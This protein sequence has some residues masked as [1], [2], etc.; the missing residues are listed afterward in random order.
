MLRPLTLFS[1]ASMNTTEY[2]DEVD[3]LRDAI[4]SFKSCVNFAEREKAVKRIQIWWR[5]LSLLEQ[6]KRLPQ[7]EVARCEK[8][9]K[10]AVDLLNNWLIEVESGCAH[11]EHPAT[12]PPAQAM[13]DTMRF[14]AMAKRNGLI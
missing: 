10:L 7:S 8:H 1:E 2:R 5:R 3:G 12:E 6:P 14:C 13:A 9:L 11:E 4:G